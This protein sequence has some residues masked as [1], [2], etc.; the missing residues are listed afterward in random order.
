MIQSETIDH[1][2][3]DKYYLFFIIKSL[4]SKR[5]IFF[6]GYMILKLFFKLIYF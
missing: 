3:S 6:S 4:I 1:I 5:L 2:F